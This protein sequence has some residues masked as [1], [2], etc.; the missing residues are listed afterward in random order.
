M[1]LEKQNSLIGANDPV[2]VTG[3]AGFI[4]SRVVANLVEKG[5]RN[6]LCL[7][8]HSTDLSRLQAIQ[9]TLSDPGRIQIITGNLLS[10]DDCLAAAK[11]VTVIYHLAAGTG[12]KSFSEAFLNSVVTT[13]NLLDAALKSSKLRRF[14]NLSSFG[15]YS[16]RQQSNQVLDE[17]W[18][19][20]EHPESRAEAYCYAKVKQD[21][22]VMEYGKTRALPYVLLRPGNVYGPGKRAIPGRV[23][24]DSFGIYLHLGGSNKIPFTF[25][26]NCAD[27]IVLA[28]LK[29]G[30]DGEVF[31]ILDDDLPSSRQFLKNYKKEVRKFRSIYLPPSL[32]YFFCFLWEKYSQWSQGQLPP[33]L[34]RAEWAAFWKPTRFSN[35]KLKNRLGWAQKISTEQG[36]QL[37]FEGCR[38]KAKHA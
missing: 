36:M 9:Q 24:I 20:E 38:Q 19:M 6:I 28:G 8:R 23:G 26:D 30:I 2:L 1:E 10:M 4:G 14:V 31:N 34:T 29:K 17:Q 5:F 11:D 25:V 7:V 27:A 12:I 15:V 21:E 35:Q 13:R 3:A 16:S 33:L 32:S 37:F 22:L 18:P